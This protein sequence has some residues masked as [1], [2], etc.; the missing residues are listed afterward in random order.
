MEINFITFFLNY[1]LKF[2]KKIPEYHKFSIIK[3]LNFS[4]IA[5][6]RPNLRFETF[7]PWRDKDIA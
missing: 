6:R 3:K 4:H 2:G 7:L 1:K 5:L